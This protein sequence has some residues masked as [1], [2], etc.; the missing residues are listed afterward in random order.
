[1]VLFEHHFWRHVPRRATVFSV[2]FRGPFSSNAE[3]SQAQVPVTVENNVFWFDVSVDDAF[4]VHSLQGLNETGNK[5]LRAGWGELS[6]AGV[7]VS[8]VTS[9]H[10]VHDQV[11]VLRIVER[12][13]DVDDE[14]GLDP[15]H[16]LQLFHHRL[17][18]LFR[19]HARL[20]HFFHRVE[21]VIFLD[22]DDLA[23]ASP[24]YCI[25]E[26]EVSFSDTLTL[27]FA[28]GILFGT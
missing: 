26:F 4:T 23:K 27:F 24:S 6:D 22:L 28:L 8:K 17:N 13:V 10:E 15:A 14:V 9:F 11:Q 7:V 12:P 1:M 21:L 3:V 20:Q 25:M 19:H 16:Q 2:V 5:K 18:A